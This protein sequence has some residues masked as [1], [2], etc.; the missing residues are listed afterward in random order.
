MHD[1]MNVLLPLLD[2]SL[3]ALAVYGCVKAT[4]R[5][6]AKRQDKGVA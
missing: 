2:G 3:I 6:K 4:R 1:T 5:R